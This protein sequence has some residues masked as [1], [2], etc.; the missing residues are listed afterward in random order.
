[1]AFLSL[2]SIVSVLTTVVLATIVATTAIQNRPRHNNQH[3]NDPSCDQSNPTICN[4][5]YNTINNNNNNDNGDV[6]TNSNTV[7]TSDMNVMPRSDSYFYAPSTSEDDP[8]DRRVSSHHHNESI[9][10][11]DPVNEPRMLSS[12]GGDVLSVSQVVAS[13]EAGDEAS[14]VTLQSN[15]N[16]HEIPTKLARGAGR[17]SRRQQL[18]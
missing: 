6:N 12:S 7:N 5:N 18:S 13:D 15:I 14:A 16:Q 11:C 9:R 3:F 1:M 17:T 8:I 10:S 4:S 2:M